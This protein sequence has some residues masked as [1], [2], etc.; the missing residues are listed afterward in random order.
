[1]GRHFPDWDRRGAYRQPLAVVEQ[2][3]TSNARNMV[4]FRPANGNESADR[5]HFEEQS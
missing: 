4:A 3:L 1:M 5:D 2:A